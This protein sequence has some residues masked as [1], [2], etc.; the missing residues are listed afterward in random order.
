MA[1]TWE[2]EDL[3]ID[4]GEEFTTF[5]IHDEEGLTIAEFAS[6]TSPRRIVAAVNHADALA[7]ALM[8]ALGANGHTRYCKCETFSCGK[9]RAELRAYDAAKAAPGAGSE[10]GT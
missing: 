8:G 2:R 9:A 3:V 1:W 6:D 5:V 7:D 4:E 10:G